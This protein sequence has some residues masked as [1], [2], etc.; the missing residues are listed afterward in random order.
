MAAAAT[1]TPSWALASM[2]YGAGWRSGTATRWASVAPTPRPSPSTTIEGWCTRSP[3]LQPG[4]EPDEEE[5]PEE[6][7]GDREQLL[8]DAARLADRGDGQ[9][10]HEAGEHQRDVR[11]DREGGHRE[12]HGQA[13]PELDRELAVLGDAVHPLADAAALDRPERQ[14]EDDAGDQD[15]GRPDRGPQRRGAGR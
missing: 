11:R 1:G 3:Q 4:A 13:D 8:G 10:G 15:D 14:E 9:A 6:A 5:R 7:L 2:A 12:H